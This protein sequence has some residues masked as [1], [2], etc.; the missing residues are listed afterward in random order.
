MIAIPRHFGLPPEDVAFVERSLTELA[1]LERQAAIM[2]ALAQQLRADRQRLEGELW[3]WKILPRIEHDLD[4]AQSAMR[5]IEC[6]RQD[7]ELA[8][9][10]LA[11]DSEKLRIPEPFDGTAP[12]RS[13][14]R[15]A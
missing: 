11:W 4:Q 9:H 7:L 12:L 14:G 8:L 15:L 3:A 6:Q 1:A 13:N 2:S 10:R 5:Q